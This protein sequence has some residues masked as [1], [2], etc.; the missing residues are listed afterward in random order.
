MVVRDRRCAVVQSLGAMTLQAAYAGEASALITALAA[1][2]FSNWPA[3]KGAVTTLCPHV[4]ACLPAG[5]R[6]VMMAATCWRAM[7]PACALSTR[8]SGVNL[9]ATHAQP[10]PPQLDGFCFSK[11]CMRGCAFEHTAP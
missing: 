8:V 7:A 1:C 4:P 3:A 9:P 5:V 10:K 2:S 6:C 11:S